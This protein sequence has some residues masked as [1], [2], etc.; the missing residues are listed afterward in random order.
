LNL[1][2]DLLNDI[3]QSLL[4]AEAEETQASTSAVADVGTGTGVWLLHMRAAYPQ[5]TTMDGFD[6]S[7]E[8]YP[9]LDTLPN[10]V[11]LHVHDVRTPFPAELHGKYDIVHTRLLMY[12]LTAANWPPAIEN[13][14]S[15]LR[16][17]GWLVC[18]D[19]GYQTWTSIPAS[20]AY[21]RFLRLDMAASEAAG[22]DLT[23]S[24]RFP[25]LFRSAGLQSR[26]ERTYFS[27]DHPDLQES[28]TPLMMRLH[29]SSMKGAIVRGG[30]EGLR[31]EDDVEEV[32][33]PIR[34]Q[35]QEGLRLGFGIRRV[36]GRKGA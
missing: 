34:K 1:G 12:A 29:E 15:L 5:I 13:L 17:N 30:V 25:S 32:M 10:G 22:R 8:K 20:E 18:E 24:H 28:V 16:P 31:N 9:A 21:A 6:L 14:V 4:P 35:I 36:W 7:A 2:V 23:F 11:R 33:R 27:W 19:V 26:D 3:F